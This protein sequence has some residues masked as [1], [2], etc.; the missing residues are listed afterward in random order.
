MWKSFIHHYN[1]LFNLDPLTLYRKELRRARIDLLSCITNK[2]HYDAMVPM[3]NKRIT[4]LNHEII[5][6]EEFFK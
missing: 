2:Q 6:L 4:Q 1:C 5:A 3:L